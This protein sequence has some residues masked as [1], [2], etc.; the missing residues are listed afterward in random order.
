MSIHKEAGNVIGLS[1][2]LARTKPEDERIKIAQ[3]AMQEA[4]TLILQAKAI[5]SL[6]R[7]ILEKGDQ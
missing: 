7:M 2:F 6:A 3:R 1:E 4:G 5:L